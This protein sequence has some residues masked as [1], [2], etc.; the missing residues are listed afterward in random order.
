[1][2]VAAADL[3]PHEALYV[4]TMDQVTGAEAEVQ[5]GAGQF[6]LRVERKCKSWVLVSR[7]E[8][9]LDFGAGRTLAI[10]SSGTTEESLDGLSLRFNQEKRMNGQLIERFKGR[11]ALTE[12]DNAG[13][14]LFDQP[15]DLRMV[16]PPGTLFPVASAIETLDNYEKGEKFQSYL[17]FNG[18]ALEGPHQVTEI[19]T[20]TVESVDHTAEG[21]IALLTGKGWRV[22]VS[23]F[24]FGAQDAEP[25]AVQRGEVLANGVIPWFS[26]DLGPVEAGARLVSLRA[27]KEPEC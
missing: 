7:L 22:T 20:G 23:F 24:D 10:E 27:L 11:A 4:L 26:I 3:V 9:T 14:A 6:V 5:G 13:L 19:V 18:D 8:F 2:P 21:D 17:M 15:P 16:L 25:T 1:M 12:D